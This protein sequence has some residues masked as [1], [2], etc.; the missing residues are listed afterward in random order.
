MTAGPRC[1]E[2][3]VCR[4]PAPA[5][6]RDRATSTSSSRTCCAASLAPGCDADDR[7]VDFGR[8]SK[9]VGLYR[10]RAT[11]GH[12]AAARDGAAAGGR[13]VRA[14]RR[15]LNFRQRARDD[16]SRRRRLDDRRVCLAT[17]VIGETF[18]LVP[19]EAKAARYLQARC[20]EPRC[21]AARAAGGAVA[22]SAPRGAHSGDGRERA[23]RRGL[24]RRSAPREALPPR[25]ADEVAARQHARR[26]TRRGFVR[27]SPTSPKIRGSRPAGCRPRNNQRPRWRRRAEIPRH[28]SNTLR[29][30]GGDRSRHRRRRRRRWLS[31]GAFRRDAPHN[32][33]SAPRPPRRS[34]ERR[35]R[36]R[37]RNAGRADAREEERVHAIWTDYTPNFD[38]PRRRFVFM[39]SVNSTLKGRRLGD[40]VGPGGRSREWLAAARQFSSCAASPAIRPADIAPA[41]AENTT[42]GYRRRRMSDIAA[43]PRPRMMA[44]VRGRCRTS[45]GRAGRRARGR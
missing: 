34:V 25:L 23:G 28:A 21:A 18:G 6:A 1:L 44:R 37:R 36:R 11:R 2:Q 19:H 17:L 35:Q 45:V 43:R 24:R 38:I 4:H 42:H 27:R 30:A 5:R 8:S 16:Q 22:C 29:R 10:P 14:A 32:A 40:S 33:C 31:A 39:S 20:D 41:S 26:D 7:P 9:K 15:R 13:R 12:R 3:M